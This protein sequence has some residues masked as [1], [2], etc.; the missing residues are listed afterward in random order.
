MPTPRDWLPRTPVRGS[1][2]SGRLL[3]ELDRLAPRRHRRR[4]AERAHFWLERRLR[5]GIAVHDEG[6]ARLLGEVAQPGEELG[7]VGVCRES[8]DR[9]NLAA[10]VEVLPVDPD[11]FRPLLQA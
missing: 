4:E 10:D 5:R 7:L 2:R 1:A 9:A 8:T 11:L 3:R 6:R